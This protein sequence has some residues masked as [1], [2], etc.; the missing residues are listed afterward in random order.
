MDLG[1]FRL[2]YHRGSQHLLRVVGL[3]EPI[4]IPI[5]ALVS[6]DVDLGRGRRWLLFGGRRQRG[7]SKDLVGVYRNEADACSAFHELRQRLDGDGWGEVL[8]LEPSGKHQQRY[9]FDVER[10]ESATPATSAK[11][12]NRW[13]RRSGDG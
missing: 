3:S 8:T 7:G 6:L 12:R 5:E 13:G 4:E 1:G 10:P 9:W 11:P 2:E